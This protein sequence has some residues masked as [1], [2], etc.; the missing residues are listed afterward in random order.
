MC[1][2]WDYQTGVRITKD[3]K[4]SCSFVDFGNLEIQQE[5]AKRNANACVREGAMDELNRIKRRC[6]KEKSVEG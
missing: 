3:L 2:G 4:I 5:L 6:G 1:N